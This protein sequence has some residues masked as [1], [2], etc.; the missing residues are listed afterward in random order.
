[1]LNPEYV[2]KVAITSNSV[3]LIDSAKE[4]KID[5]DSEIAITATLENYVFSCHS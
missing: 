2:A 5:E 4:Q 3:V 1:M